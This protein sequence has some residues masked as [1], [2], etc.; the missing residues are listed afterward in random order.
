MKEHWINAVA[1]VPTF[2]KKVRETSKYRHLLVHI[3]GEA[4]N[5]LLDEEEEVN[6]RKQPLQLTR[7]VVTRWGSRL[8]AILRFLELRDAVTRV[9]CEMKDD[10]KAR[11]PQNSDFQFHD[12]IEGNEWVHKKN[13]FLSFFFSNVLCVRACGI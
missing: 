11:C 1:Y 3:Q 13:L 7:E 9:A 12:E 6:F 4:A 5:E 8:A 2:I 10:P